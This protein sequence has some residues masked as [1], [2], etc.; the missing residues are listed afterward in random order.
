[1]LGSQRNVQILHNVEKVKISHIL[2]KTNLRRTAFTHGLCV[3]IYESFVIG[4]FDEILIIMYYRRIRQWY[5][6]KISCLQFFVAFSQQ[7]LENVTLSLSLSSQ[8]YTI[9]TTRQVLRI[10][11]STYWTF[12]EQKA[13]QCASLQNKMVLYCHLGFI[14]SHTIDLMS[15]FE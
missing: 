13:V 6:Y 14:L 3:I 7:Y 4:E 11:C 8:C 12:V 2:I 9:I 5:D 10:Y 15:R 1:M